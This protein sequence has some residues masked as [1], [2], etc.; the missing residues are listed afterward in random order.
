MSGDDLVAAFEAR[1][2][3]RGETV[4]AS[5]P[6]DS[7]HCEGVA[8]LTDRRLCFYGKGLPGTQL[9]NISVRRETLRYVPSQSH[10]GL[11]AR[12]ETDEGALVFTVASAEAGEALGALLGKLRDLREAQ[13]ALTEAGYTPPPASQEE[14]LS[15]EYKLIRLRE[16]LNMG[17]LGEEEYLLQRSRMIEE[18]CREA[19][20]G[21]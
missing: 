17:F 14:T 19:S 3:E 4:L 15:A 8:I 2:R 18:M 13:E 20:P 16:L 11:T 1:R 5:V 6:A 10:E 7:V 21:R 12:F 9:E